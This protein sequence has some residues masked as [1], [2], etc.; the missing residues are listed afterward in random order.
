MSIKRT[1]NDTSILLFPELD[2]STYNRKATVGINDWR[3]KYGTKE[4]EIK[5]YINNLTSINNTTSETIADMIQTNLL[6]DIDSDVN[7]NRYDIIHTLNN[8]RTSYD[9]SGETQT[10]LPLHTLTDIEFDGTS[11]KL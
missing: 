5:N 11:E 10:P 8:I 2:V 4:D 7:T 3:K 9:D 1:G 6:K